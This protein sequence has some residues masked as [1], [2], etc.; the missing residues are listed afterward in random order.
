MPHER[1]WAEEDF[2]A[3]IDGEANRRLGILCLLYNRRRSNP[4]R[5]G[6]SVLEFESV[7]SLPREHLIFTLWYLKDCELI[8]Q[9]ETSNFVIT[10]RGV[11]H[12]RRICR[13]TISSIIC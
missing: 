3:G 7:M 6:I 2:V 5:P 12:V 8:R 9:D 10:G 13:P 11:D 4:D 1:L